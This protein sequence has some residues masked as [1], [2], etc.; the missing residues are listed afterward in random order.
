M[1]APPELFTEDAE[2]RDADLTPPTAEET[3]ALK[4]PAPEEGGVSPEDADVGCARQFLR[5]HCR[6]PPHQGAIRAK[7]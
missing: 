6:E 3:D 4:P 1:A 2:A 5:M 7:M